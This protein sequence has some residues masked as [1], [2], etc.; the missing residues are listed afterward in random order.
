[1]PFSIISR[2]NKQGHLNSI[3][4]AL[5]G[6]RKEKQ[7]QKQKCFFSMER[8]QKGMH[9]VECFVPLRRPTPSL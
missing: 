6:N 7:K 2:E 5:K 3:A 8:S 9:T 4:A 1:M